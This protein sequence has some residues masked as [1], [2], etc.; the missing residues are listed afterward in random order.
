MPSIQHFAVIVSVVVAQVLGFLWYSVGFGRRWAVGYRLEADAMTK[1]SPASL[2]ITLAGAV[3]FTYAIA[4]L[5]A[6][7]G[8]QGLLAGATGGALVF[9]GIVLPRYLLHAVFARVAKGSILID[10]GFDLIVSV[11]TGAILGVWLP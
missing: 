5:F 11:V 2:G 9:A 1:S 4:A 8:V 7:V 6:L 3:L 10:V